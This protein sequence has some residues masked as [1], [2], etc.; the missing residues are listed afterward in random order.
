MDKIKHLSLFLCPFFIF[1]LHFVRSL[2]SFCLGFG[3]PSNSPHGKNTHTYTRIHSF[4]Q[5]ILDSPRIDGFHLDCQI[6]KGSIA[7]A[8]KIL[9]SNNNNNKIIRYD[10]IWIIMIIMIMITIILNIKYTNILIRSNILI[11]MYAR[12]IATSCMLRS[13][14][15]WRF[16]NNSNS[17][18]ICMHCFNRS[19][20][21]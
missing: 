12:H 11:G 4:I 2:F 13:F 19:N 1:V 10:I 3:F 14:D 21:M 17:C 6:V 15:A 8:V 18:M 5:F 20:T 7:W 16:L 9:I